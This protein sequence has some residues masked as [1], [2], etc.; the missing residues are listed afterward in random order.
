MEERIQ[1]WPR[2][3][4]NVARL[5]GKRGGFADRTVI[6][7]AAAIVGVSFTLRRLFSA[8]R[9]VSTF[10]LVP[11]FRGDAPTFSTRLSINFNIVLLGRA[12]PPPPP[13]DRYKSAFNSADVRRTR[14]SVSLVH[15]LARSVSVRNKRVY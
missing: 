1:R 5:P 7:A 4:R 14:A 15:S 2:Y 11:W 9:D 13:P 3:A 10:S 12:R 8:S 6:V